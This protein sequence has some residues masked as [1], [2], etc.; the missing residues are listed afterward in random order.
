[1]NVLLV[2]D[3]EGHARLIK[4][5]L[6]RASPRY[7]VQHALSVADALQAMLARPIDVALLDLTLPDSSGT[8]TVAAIRGGCRDL[9][10]VVLTSLAD[11]EMALGVMDEGAQ[12]YLAK[13]TVTPDGL[14]RSIRYAVHRQQNVSENERL[15]KDLE[16]SRELLEKKNRRV[17]KLYR[18]AHRFVNNVSH[19]FRTP[20]TVVKEYV[21]LM[22]DGLLG[23]LN[24][25]QR[26]F[27]DI[28]NDRADDLNHMVDDMLDVSKLEAGI[29]TIYRVHARLSDIVKHV[30]IGL[31]RRAALKDVH[32]DIAV[33]EELPAVFCDSE[34]VGRVIVNL[35]VNAIKFCGNPGHV[36]LEASL[37]ECQQEMVVKVS[38][39]GQGI[40][41]KDLRVIFRRFKQLGPNPRG[42]TKG[43]GLGLSI[44]KELVLLNLG[45][46]SVE[47]KVG[48]GSIFSFTVPL[49]NPNEVLR[50][51]LR[52]LKASR[53]DGKTVSLALVSADS[54]IDSDTTEDVTTF[55]SGSLRRNDLLFYRGS[56]RWL[57][58]LSISAS[59]LDAFFGR[60]RQSATDSN[61]NRFG[62]PLPTLQMDAIGQWRVDGNVNEVMDSLENAARPR[63]AQSC[64]NQSPTIS[65]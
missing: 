44:A 58:V 62:R 5:A 53:N 40:S 28:V 45:E 20:L 43:F 61:R 18:T 21:S 35:V 46:M 55:L 19:E 56:A 22:R 3:N 23:P 30:R 37:S 34:K 48:K 25:E 17:S 32:L 50:R 4:S 1:M 51:Y 47:S 6:R 10:I 26:R 8:A 59:E 42:S 13:D 54:T 64:L 57:M 39:N 41:R 49:D 7:E 11:D 29:L 12:D 60:L 15:V 24:D 27:L 38:D 52:R 9:P 33:D 36:R 16:E 63:E 14:A 2:E 31:E 65:L